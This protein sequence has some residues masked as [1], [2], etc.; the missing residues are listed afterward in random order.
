MFLRWNLCQRLSKCLKY[1]TTSRVVPEHCKGVRSRNATVRCARKTNIVFNII[2][3]NNFVQKN[4][5]YGII[6]HAFQIKTM[7]VVLYECLFSDS[8]AF[9]LL[10]TEGERKTDLVKSQLFYICSN[11]KNDLSNCGYFRWH[12]RAIK[13]DRNCSSYRAQRFELFFVVAKTHS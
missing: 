9:E 3:K 7:M 5:V 4:G 13:N 8:L 2:V 10:E 11:L 12:S 6:V 1:P